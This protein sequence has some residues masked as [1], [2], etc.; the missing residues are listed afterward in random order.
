MNPARILRYLSEQSR[1]LSDRQVTEHFGLKL[2]DAELCENVLL[3]LPYDGYVCEPEGEFRG[4]AISDKGRAGLA[5]MSK[6][7]VKKREQMSMFG[8]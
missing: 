4:W 7:V 5:E 3:D 8:G 6:P 2:Q 1:P